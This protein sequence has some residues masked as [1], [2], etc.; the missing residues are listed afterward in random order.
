MAIMFVTVSLL[1]SLFFVYSKTF[2]IIPTTLLNL[3]KILSQNTNGQK[4]VWKWKLAMKILK[5]VLA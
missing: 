1:L 3:D 2:L 5:D 4:I